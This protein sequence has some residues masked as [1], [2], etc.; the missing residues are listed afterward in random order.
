MHLLTDAQQHSKIKTFSH[1]PIATQAQIIDAILC[2]YAGATL[3]HDYSTLS[4]IF[5]QPIAIK[6]VLL[7]LSLYYR[8]SMV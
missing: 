5:L 8:F 7:C 6:Y 1:F 4:T 2:I 3:V